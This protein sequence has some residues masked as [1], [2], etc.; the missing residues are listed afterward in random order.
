MSKQPLTSHSKSSS[1]QSSQRW[2]IKIGSALLTDDGLGLDQSRIADWCAQLAQLKQQGIEV[3]LVS[4]GAVAVGMTEMGWQSRP[5]QMHQL[6]AA[7]AIGQT[8]LV[9]FY[10]Q[11]F[12]QHQIKTA[13]ILLTHD[14]LADRTRYLNAK[15]TI[16]A[17]LQMG[18][19]PI[20][21]EN[22]TVVTDEIRFGDN[23]TLAALVANLLVADRLLILTDQLGLYDSDPRHNA[24]AALISQASASDAGLL[25][26]ATGGG[27]LG[28]GGMFTKVKAA[29]LAARSGAST[30]IASGREQNVISRLFLGETVGTCLTADHP[31]INARK[32]WLAGHLQTKGQLWL[33][34]GAVAAIKQTGNSLLPV[35]VVKIAGQFRRGEVVDFVDT[36]QHVFARGLINF[37]AQ[38]AQKILGQ[39]SKKLVDILGYAC[40]EELVHYDNLVLI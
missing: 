19:L 7:A 13:Q 35:G 37:D 1:N 14:D 3:I 16:S 24:G 34:A 28:R 8:K 25:K 18:V 27:A 31:P 9:Q 26:M 21:N 6:Q 2:V 4:S 17:L 40:D 15:S 5:T 22:D 39:S 32:Q 38:D 33:D 36:Q 20:V 23:D 11:C 10:E 12:N 30:H 29:R